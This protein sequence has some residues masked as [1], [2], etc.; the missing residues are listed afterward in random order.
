MARK[1]QGIEILPGWQRRVGSFQLGPAFENQNA[2]RQGS[3]PFREGGARRRNRCC[4]SRGT[5]SILANR[6]DR[7][8]EPS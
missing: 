4:G 8:Q 7:R 1:G 5:G 3:P 6:R 2:W